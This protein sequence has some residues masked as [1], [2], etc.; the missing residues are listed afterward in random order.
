M[1]SLAMIHPLPP[2]RKKIMQKIMQ[3]NVTQGNAENVTGKRDRKTDRK[4]GAA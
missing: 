4:T 1:T 2:L 3:N